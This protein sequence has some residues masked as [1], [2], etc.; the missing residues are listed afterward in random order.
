MRTDGKMAELE[1]EEI[2]ASLCRDDNEKRNKRD[3]E[4]RFEARRPTLNTEGSGTRKN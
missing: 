1:H 4:S 3:G 2:V